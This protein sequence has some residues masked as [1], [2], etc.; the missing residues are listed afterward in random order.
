MDPLL[1]P[2]NMARARVVCRHR[3]GHRGPHQFDGF[4]VLQQAPTAMAYTASALSFMLENLD[5]PVVLTG[6]LR[7]PAVPAA[8]RRA[9]RSC[10]LQP[11]A[12]NEVSLYF[13]GQLSRQSHLQAFYP[14]LSR[15]GGHPLRRKRHRRAPG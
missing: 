8:Q 15:R 12:C 13:G 11:R 10:S 6:S 7:D 9:G 4:V 14:R 1:Q 5:K 3:P 2:S